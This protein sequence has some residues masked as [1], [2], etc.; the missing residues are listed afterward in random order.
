MHTQNGDVAAK[1]QDV[2]MFFLDWPNVENV[3]KFRTSNLEMSTTA[4]SNT[5]ITEP[6]I[7]AQNVF[8]TKNR[9]YDKLM[10]KCNVSNVFPAQKKEKQ[11]F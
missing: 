11:Q 5:K 9:I 1:M 4:K 6:V 7:C 10:V 3:V 8:Y 2:G